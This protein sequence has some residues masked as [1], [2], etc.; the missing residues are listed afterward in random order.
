M[1][2]ILT[3]EVLEEFSTMLVLLAAYLIRPFWMILGDG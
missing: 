3:K 2:A 1:S